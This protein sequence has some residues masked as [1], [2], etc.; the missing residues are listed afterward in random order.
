MHL[1]SLPTRFI[2]TSVICLCLLLTIS[3]QKDSAITSIL[4]TDLPKNGS[5]L[6]LDQVLE[7]GFER[8]DVVDKGDHYVI[9]GDI[10]FNKHLKSRN[11]R[12]SQTLVNFTPLVA[13]YFSPFVSIAVDN[14]FPNAAWRQKVISATQAA[15]SN[16]NNISSCRINI[17][18]NEEFTPDIMIRYNPSFA[19]GEY[20]L[21]SWPEN[22]QPGPSI[23]LNS[24]SETMTDSRLVYVIT[25]EIGHNFGFM[26]TDLGNFN[27]FLAP[28][29][30]E[31]DPQSIMNSGP[32]AG[33]TPDPNSIPQW[34]SFSE[35]DL[36]AS[37][38][39]YGDNIVTQISFEKIGQ[40]GSNSQCLIRWQVSRFCSTTIR[41]TVYKDGQK[42]IESDIPNNSNYRPVLPPGLYQIRLCY[43]GS[44]LDTQESR[45][46]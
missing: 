15:I 46:N 17:T 44:C 10:K 26:H 37:R 42:F 9:Q 27:N 24:Q 18:Y 14:S 4:P 41:A 29:S 33:L 28:Y 20:G 31:S 7:L 19:N 5:D 3:C 2:S 16:W 45:L 36:S 8:S 38:A 30:P 6:T 35:W 1:F 40:Q 13:S 22:C 21:G 34:N 39:V 12:S 43:G 25:H 11:A 23:E 32:F